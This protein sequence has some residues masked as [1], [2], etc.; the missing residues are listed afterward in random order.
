[1]WYWL[2]I[3][4]LFNTLVGPSE[5]LVYCLNVVLLIVNCFRYAEEQQDLA[6]LSISTFQRALKVSSSFNKAKPLCFQNYSLCINDRGLPKV[7]V[8][9]E[10]GQN[11]VCGL[12]LRAQRLLLTVCCCVNTCKEYT[13]GEWVVGYITKELKA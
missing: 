9:C 5:W 6:L 1:M 2:H 11:T 12:D 8:W 4:P 10:F 13:S 3:Q 7:H